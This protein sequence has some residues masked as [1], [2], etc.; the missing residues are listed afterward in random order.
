MDELVKERMRAT[1]NI[2]LRSNQYDQ[3]KAFNRLVGI[4]LSKQQSSIVDRMISAGNDCGA[5]Y[6]AA[7]YVRMRD[8]MMQE[9][10]L[11]FSEVYG[12]MQQQGGIS[13]DEKNQFR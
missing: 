11:Q 13:V 9:R 3:S 4:G 5:V 10:F 2:V 12:I 7:A 6:G 8:L 1:Q